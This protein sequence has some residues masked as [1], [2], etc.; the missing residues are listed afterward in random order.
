M[1]RQRQPGKRFKHIGAITREAAQEPFVAFLSGVAVCATPL[2]RLQIILGGGK[3]SL[4]TDQ[5][6]SRLNL[7]SLCQ[8]RCLIRHTT[9]F[10][11]GVVAGTIHLKR[12]TATP[13]L[14]TLG[15]LHP[16]AKRSSQ[17][18]EKEPEYRRIRRP[19]D[20]N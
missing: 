15:P 14:Y 2:D 18:K 19:T 12:L 16:V 7:G 3:L 8:S 20:E 5:L 10:F 11:L 1:P 9:I 6:R 4:T 17:R 13:I